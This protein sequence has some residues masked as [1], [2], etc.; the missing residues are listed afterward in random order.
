MIKRHRRIAGRRVIRA[1]YVHIAVGLQR[2]HLR[3]ELDRPGAPATW[4]FCRI[5]LNS[6]WVAA[7]CGHWKSV[8]F[9]MRTAAP[10]LGTGT[11][12]RC[13]ESYHFSNS[14]R[15]SCEPC[16]A[17]ARPGNR[18]RHGRLP[19]EEGDGG[20]GARREQQHD[21]NGHRPSQD[22]PDITERTTWNAGHGNVVV[23]MPDTTNRPITADVGH[24]AQKT[25]GLED[26]ER[27][28]GEVQ[29]C[30]QADRRAH[31]HVARQAL[32]NRGDPPTCRQTRSSSTKTKKITPPRATDT[33]RSCRTG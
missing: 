19:R 33:P 11:V 31:E 20:H 4:Y 6:A 5:G 15:S 25:H 1:A 12:T 18:V 23:A 21:E 30:R 29:D 17:D 26:E 8:N 13:S 7:H 3:H 32:G 10:P 28:V 22:S 9:T 14:P 27:R 24:Q 16:G 2:V